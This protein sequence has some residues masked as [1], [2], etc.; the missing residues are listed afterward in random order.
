M[1]VTIEDRA[2]SKIRIISLKYEIKIISTS[3]FMTRVEILTTPQKANTWYNK[4]S[5]II[6]ITRDCSLK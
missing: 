3:M 6:L 2:R 4:I 5:L 1:A